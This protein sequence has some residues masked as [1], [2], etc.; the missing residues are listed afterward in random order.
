LVS[1]SSWNSRGPIIRG[2]MEALDP[3][4]GDIR[5]ETHTVILGGHSPSGQSHVA[6][7]GESLA[8]AT[9]LFTLGSST[10]GAAPADAQA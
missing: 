2:G 3:G 8:M 10:G 9:A 5:I 4:D 6:D 1:A 7:A